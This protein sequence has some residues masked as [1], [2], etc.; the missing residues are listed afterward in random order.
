MSSGGGLLFLTL[1]EKSFV[2]SLLLYMMGIMTG[3]LYPQWRASDFASVQGEL[4]LPIAITQAIIYG[5]GTLLVLTRWR[6]VAGAALR[7]WPVL[8]LFALAPISALWSIYPALTLRRS[9]LQGAVLVMAVYLGERYSLREFSGYL[10]QAFAVMMVGSILVFL[11][12]PSYVTDPDHEG[13][14]RG[15][16]NQKNAF[17]HEMAMAFLLFLLMRYGHFDRLRYIFLSMSLVLMLL[18]R[19]MTAVA[20][21]VIV[22]ATLPLWK[23]MGLPVRQRIQGVIFGSAAML[24]IAIPLFNSSHTIFRLLG[25]DATMTGRTEVWN[26]VM[27]AIGRHPWLGYGF[28]SFWTGLRG[29]S[30]DV[31]VASGWL[32]PQAHNGYLEVLLGM[33]I[34]GALA[35]AATIFMAFR[36]CLQ[37]VREDGRAIALWPAAFLGLFLL[38]NLG[39]SDIMTNGTTFGISLFITIF[40]SLALNRQ[41]E[42]TNLP[43]CQIEGLEPKS[44]M[45][46]LS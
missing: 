17:G 25:R 15:L 11:V 24:A 42:S 39:E 44:N 5:L 18:S 20:S 23:A 14:W 4:H 27:I 38:H 36:L 43:E 22:L 10:G 21:C 28:C 33:G 29:E 34:P 6:R 12:S 8:L 19:S 45:L 35:F 46:A 37:C 26:A 7:I 41:K 16:A 2:I 40:T 1:L 3:V 13:A 30:L 31:I 32:V 9:L